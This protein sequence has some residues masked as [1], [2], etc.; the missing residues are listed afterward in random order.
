MRCSRRPTA[1]GC[2]THG[3]EPVP[4]PHA[5]GV[6]GRAEA[7][8]SR[9]S[10]SS[11]SLAAEPPAAPWK[12]RIHATCSA[13]KLASRRSRGA[14]SQ[15]LRA[16]RGAADIECCGWRGPGFSFPELNESALHGSG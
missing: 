7:Y 14:R 5:L 8:D 16:R 12:H 10:R 4:L 2:G 1:G 13:R 9:G 15:V 11:I 3:Y 6:R